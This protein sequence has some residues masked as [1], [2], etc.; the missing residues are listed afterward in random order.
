[1]NKMN[2]IANLIYVFLGGGLLFFS[3]PVAVVDQRVTQLK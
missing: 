1:M 3:A 2:K